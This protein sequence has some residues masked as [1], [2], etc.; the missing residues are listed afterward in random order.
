MGLASWFARPEKP[1]T[2]TFCAAAASREQFPIG[3]LGEL[4]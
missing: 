4:I 3:F 2:M 1:A